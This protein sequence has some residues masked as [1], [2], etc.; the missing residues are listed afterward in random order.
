[1]NTRCLTIAI[2]LAAPALL[3]DAAPAGAQT[4]EVA[5]W[6]TIGTEAMAAAGTDPLT[7][8]RVLAILHLAMHDA[9]NTLEPRY[10]TYA[11]PLAGATAGAS[12]EAAVA[13]AAH[14]ALTTLLPGGRAR[15]DAEL[16]ATLD[17][18]GDT[19]AREAGRTTGCEAARAVL[20]MRTNDGATRTVTYQAGTRPGAYRP[21]PPDF[22]P[23]FLP[24]WGTLTPF[25]LKSA[26]QF[27]PPA[28]PPVDSGLARS[29]I[30]VVQRIGGAASTARTA[31]QSEIAKFWYESSPQGWNRIAREI[32]VARQLDAWSAARLLALLNVAMAD[33]FIGGFE[34][35]Y[36]YNYWR[37]V[38]AIRETTDATWS[39]NLPTPPV[40]DYPSTHTV[41]GAAAATVLARVFETDYVSFEATSGAPYAGI[42]RSFWSFSQ[43]AQENGA[44]RVL[45]GIHFPTAVRAG[46]EQGERIGA[47]TVETLLAPVATPRKT[48]T[49]AR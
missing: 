14:E 3:A 5:R 21:T 11:A 9:L 41:L 30:A 6:N 40:P 1:M 49:A 2:A 45:A 38:T 19:R 12:A 10:R 8:S 15:F 48:T 43:A 44:S 36:H 13:A 31:A 4:G 34:A 7:E 39:T 20:G 37:P 26:D 24:H 18:I 47:Y 27:R 33:G 22:T 29:D 42:T 23:A 46:Y 16:R 25:A 28:P 17:A 32:A 35:K